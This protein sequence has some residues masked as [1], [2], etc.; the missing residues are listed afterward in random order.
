[1]IEEDEPTLTITVIQDEGALRLA[2]AGELDLYTVPQLQQA[3]DKSYELPRE[4]LILDLQYLDF[5]DSAGLAL[6]I[7]AQ[8]RLGKDRALMLLVSTEGQVRQ[9]FELSHFDRY[10]HIQ[11][12]HEEKLS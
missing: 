2:V 12:A 6:L 4:A 7:D 1:M 9:V 5:I 11:V 8:R 3:L 10:F